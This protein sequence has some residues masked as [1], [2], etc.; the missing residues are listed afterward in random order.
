MLT[1]YDTID[2]KSGYMAQRAVQSVCDETKHY[3]SGGNQ[4]KI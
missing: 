2:R 4:L 3:D 1:A